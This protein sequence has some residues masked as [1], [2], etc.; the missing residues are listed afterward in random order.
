MGKP[1]KVGST[2]GGKN[3]PG[4]LASVAT[5]DVGN[6]P[7]GVRV[8]SGVT[9]ARTVL[10]GVSVRPLFCGAKPHNAKPTQ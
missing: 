3:W 7:P 4:V 8:A 10:L 1:P 9:V 2:G 6:R 5:P